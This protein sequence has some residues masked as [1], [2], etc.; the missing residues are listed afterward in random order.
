M[1]RLSAFGWSRVLMVA[2]LLAA[3]LTVVQCAHSGDDDDDVIL[4]SRSYQGHASDRDNNNLVSV[5]PKIYGT[6]L[7]DC[8]TCHRGQPVI[9]DK[10]NTVNPNPCSYC[11]Y[12]I[13][14]PAGWTNLPTKMYQTLNQFGL[15]YKMYGRSEA[16]LRKIA[17]LDSDGDGFTNKEEILDLRYPGSADSYPGLA[18]CP[19][20]TVSMSDIKALPKH[21]Q[22][23]LAN[24]TKQQFDFYATYG[25]VKIIDLLADQGLA[26]ATLA[27]ATNVDILSPDGFSQTFTVAEITNQ[28]PYHQFFPGFGSDLLAPNCAF[29]EYPDNTYTYG[30]G[31]T[32][33][34]DQWHILA[35]EREGLPLDPVWLDPVTNRIEGEGPFR[36]VIP[37]GNSDPLLNQPDRG[38]N[39]DL[40]GCTMPEWNYNTLKDHNAGRMNKGAVIIRIQPMPTTCEEFDLI[41]GG[42]GLADAEQVLIYGHG[43]E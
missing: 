13:H 20:L 12:I 31:D 7:D 43:V 17:D 9:D 26:G 30:Y 8:Q 36:N 3:A 32:I 42:F 11:H 34:D 22:F 38:K 25:G 28:F 27:A 39:A 23:G 14:P 24:T 4:S 41:N 16:A 37:P 29:V 40:T 35:Y 15:D 10:A 18:M 6:R 21:V 5:Y 33:T 2:A 1:K 19:T